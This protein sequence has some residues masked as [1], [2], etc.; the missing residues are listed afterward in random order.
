MFRPVEADIPLS[1]QSVADIEEKALAKWLF[2]SPLVPRTVLEVLG[3]DAQCRV[4]LEVN[5]SSFLGQRSLPGD[6]DVLVKHALRPN[7]TTAIEFK[8]VK[9]PARAFLTGL[10]NKIRDLEHGVHQAN[11]LR[12]LGFA[13]VILL[14][15]IVTDGRERSH[16]NWAYRGP[17]SGHLR[18]IRNFPG[19]DR[20]DSGVGL[21]FLE[22]T[23]PAD[24]PIEAAG[25]I[26]VYFQIEPALHAQN[27]RISQ[28]V[29]I[30]FSSPNAASN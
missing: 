3:F 22:I 2:T 8:R 13:R 11:A 9:I 4:A 10:P 25:S 20:L 12:S 6:I 30:W 26:G 1:A 16:V 21:G 23:Q 14:V 27:S 18:R 15:A 19:R 17:T 5:S 24:K 28:A 7:V 29:N